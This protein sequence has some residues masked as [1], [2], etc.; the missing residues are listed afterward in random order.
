M[1]LSEEQ[2]GGDRQKQKGKKEEQK[3]RKEQKKGRIKDRRGEREG[4]GKDGGRGR[5]ERRNRGR[6]I[7]C[8]WM[9]SLKAIHMNRNQMQVNQW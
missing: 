9:L 3:R 4:G 1:T 7:S 8:Y 6:T 2:E 5:T